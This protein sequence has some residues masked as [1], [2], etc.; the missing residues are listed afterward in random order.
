MLE[1][2]EARPDDHSRVL[3]LWLRL[4]D[5]HRALS[6]DFP[7]MPGIASAIESEIRR[8]ASSRNCRLLVA[9]IEGQL[10]GF[11]FAEVEIVGGSHAEPAPGW[12]HELFVDAPHRGRGVAARL[13]EGSNAFFAARGAKKVSVRVESS[14]TEALEYWGR[15]GFG[16]R[17]RILERVS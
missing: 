12:I 6:R 11:L 1:I 2:R 4:I 5:H 7:T 3:E 15:R 10:I 16:E 13:I 14:N 17:A 8:A 9:Q